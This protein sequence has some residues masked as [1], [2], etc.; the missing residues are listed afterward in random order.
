MRVRDGTVFHICFCFSPRFVFGCF[1]FALFTP[2]WS[3][4][5][6]QQ[7]MCFSCF[8]IFV[9]VLFPIFVSVFVPMRRWNP[10]GPF[11]AGEAANTI[12]KRRSKS[13]WGP[14]RRRAPLRE[15]TWL[16]CQLCQPSSHLLRIAAGKNSSFY[17]FPIFVSVF[18]RYA[19]E[20]RPARSRR[21]AQSSNSGA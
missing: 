5:S 8:L 16:P 11:P 7:N 20:T 13:G 3:K 18:F 14:R 6:P 9:F 21:G 1:P 2:V 19:A 12:R 17:C 4:K 10:A 15:F